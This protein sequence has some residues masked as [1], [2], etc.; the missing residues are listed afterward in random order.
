M[1]GRAIDLARPRSVHKRDYLACSQFIQIVR[2][3][4]NAPQAIDLAS[5]TRR[6][7]GMLQHMHVQIR[8]VAAYNE[9]PML[10]RGKAEIPQASRRAA[11]AKCR[12]IPGYR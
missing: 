8:S 12:S 3:G 6:Q 1:H 7:Q 9:L 4:T 11:C 10:S 5:D 2:I